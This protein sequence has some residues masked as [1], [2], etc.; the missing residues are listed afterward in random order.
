MAAVM[1]ALVAC[2]FMLPLVVLSR[3]MENVEWTPTPTTLAVHAKDLARPTL[4]TRRAKEERTQMV[5]SHPSTSTG[6]SH[7]QLPDG[8]EAGGPGHEFDRAQMGEGHKSAADAS[9]LIEAR[10]GSAVARRERS[11]WLPEIFFSHGGTC[12]KNSAGEPIGCHNGCVCGWYEMCYPMVKEGVNIGVC[13]SSLGALAVE[14]VVLFLGV[15]FAVVVVRLWLQDQAQLMSIQ[16]EIVMD[17]PD[18]VPGAAPAPV[19]W[20]IG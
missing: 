6:L 1:V 18:E 2:L 20:P 7:S 14:S 10:S 19:K 4:S 5:S 3:R 17:M 13:G 15:T 16:E 8:V 11:R 9:V 12:T